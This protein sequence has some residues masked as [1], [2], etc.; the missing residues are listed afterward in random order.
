MAAKAGPGSTANANANAHTTAE[1]LPIAPN[2]D[3]NGEAPCASMPQIDD[4][5][6][7]ELPG[8]QH[9]DGRIRNPVPSKLK[10]KTS[11]SSGRF[12]VMHMDIRGKDMAADRDLA[13]K[14]TSENTA[15]AAQKAFESGY[16]PHRKSNWM[17]VTEEQADP[18]YE[19]M[20]RKESVRR[21]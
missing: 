3:V 19:P 5:E 9:K 15:M 8:Q 21:L 4:L 13:A 2:T 18:R 10:G 16:Q 1:L 12:S 20:V 17:R 6:V 7:Q 14:R 11:A